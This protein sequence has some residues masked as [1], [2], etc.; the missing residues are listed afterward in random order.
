MKAIRLAVRPDIVRRSLLVSAVVGTIL[1]LIN[2][3]EALFDARALHLAKFLLTY[4]VPYCVATYGS[5]MALLQ[6]NSN[7]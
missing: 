5:V 4:L 3:H 1:N 7:K 2:Q 6:L